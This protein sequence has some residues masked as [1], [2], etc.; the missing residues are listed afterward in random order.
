[1][2]TNK[3][4][5]GNF[6]YFNS[7]VKEKI[8]NIIV[9]LKKK[10]IQYNIYY[11]Y[12]IIDENDKKSYVKGIIIL[13]NKI[14][15]LYENQEEKEVYGSCLMNYLTLDNS[16]FKITRNYDKYVE[17]IDLFEFNEEYLNKVIK[18]KKIKFEI[19]EIRKI[20]RAIQKAYNLSSDDDREVSSKDT[21]GYK[22][23]E[24]NTYIG[25][26]DSTQFNMV[27]SDIKTHQRI[28]GLAGSGKTILML[29]KIARTHYMYP[30]LDLAF[31]FY[32]KSLKE[33]VIKKFK[34]FYKDYDRFNEPNMQKVKIYHAWGGKGNKGFY[35]EIC[36]LINCSPLTYGDLKNQTD[37]FDF[38]CKELLMK[39]DENENNNFFD[40]IFIDEAQDF[41][42]SFFKLCL[43][44]LK[45]EVAEIKNRIKTGFLIYA[46]DELQSL[47]EDV[48]IPTKNQIFGKNIECEDINLSISYRT[49]VEILVSA[50]AIGLGVYRKIE[51]NEEISLVNFVDKKTL[52]DMGYINE[53]GEINEGEKVKLKR[54]EEKKG[55]EIDK[56]L[57]FETENDEYT[58]VVENILELLENQDVKTQDIMII[59]LD[60]HYLQ[61]DYEEF[62]KIFYEKISEK[63]KLKNIS[64]NLVDKNN[65]N[66]VKIE[67][68]ITYTT[69]YRAKGNEANLVFVLNCDSI[70]LS[71]RNSVARNKIF[72]AMTRAKWKVWLYGKEM[73]EYSYEIE[74]V[75]E[76]DYKLEFIYPTKEQRKK[77]KQLGD[78]EEKDK[79]NVEEIA[80]IINSSGLDKSTI[81]LLLKKTLEKMK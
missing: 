47:R 68:C 7:E 2:I 76:S 31:I 36:E 25:N 12:P 71:S 61:R 57:S 40:M 22:L 62:S 10:E 16:L 8:S 55:I 41:S 77:I 49:P 48:T 42:L 75:K 6:D 64:L 29:K 44:V 81:E 65:P 52:V 51:N 72:T 43:K 5:F 69:I 39:L 13:E 4:E 38:A 23:K 26:Y 66:R 45:K 20:N 3:N 35:S 56:P 50:H 74:K 27:E 73:N 11:G 21:L 14:I 54:I 80:K 37:P 60:Q 15:L 33:D 58:A 28:R 24:R 1:M 19:D 30:K 32:T 53:N 79:S 59:D 9:L 17:E 46:Y 34:R 70:S 67:N 18:D 78:K 63:E